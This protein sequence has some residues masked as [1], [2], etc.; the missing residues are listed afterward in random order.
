MLLKALIF[1][2]LGGLASAAM[3]QPA[4]RKP[5]AA[6]VVDFHASQCVAFR[7]YGTEENPLHLVLKS[8]PLGD[9]MQV[10]VMRRGSAAAGAAQVEATVGVDDRPVVRANMLMFG[11]KDEKLRL[12]RLNMPSSDF[13][14]VKE[15][16]RLAI[17]SEGLNETFALSQMG[18]LLKIMDDCA[19]DLRKVW[20]IT[21][22]TGEQSPLA[23]RAVADLVKLFSSLDYP[24]IALQKGQSGIVSFALL[25]D[26]QGRVA[27]CTVMD[28]SGVASLDA[29]TCSVLTRRA[30]FK[31]GRDRDGKPAKDAITGRIKWVNRS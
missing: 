31:P 26:E 20:N 12:Y 11:A 3:A 25:I 8:P 22:T 1:L 5:T 9:A 23:T 14:A 28:T 21:D 24:A 13:A 7:T 4:P 17:R 6:W 2:T 18:P 27:D 29:Q 15:A 19:A 16:K 10:T 30:K